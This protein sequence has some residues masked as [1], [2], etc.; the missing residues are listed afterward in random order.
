MDQAA[1]TTWS[2]GT[3]WKCLSKVQTGAFLTSAD[4]AIQISF[5]GIGVPWTLSVLYNIAY[6][7]LSSRPAGR[8]STDVSPSRS[9]KNR[10]LL[11]PDFVAMSSP[12]RNSASTAAGTRSLSKRPNNS[13]TPLPFSRNAISTFVS[14]TTAFILSSNL[15]CQPWRTTL[16]PQTNAN[17]PRLCETIHRRTE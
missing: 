17:S 9:S 11:T 16:H 10:A 7:R 12:A 4:A 1:S 13:A 3:W 15:P 14:T 6:F 5:I 8:N 2:S